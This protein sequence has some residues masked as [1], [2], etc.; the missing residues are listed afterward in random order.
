MPFDV[1]YVVLFSA[2]G[3][4]TSDVQQ[5]YRNIFVCATM[6]RR[7]KVTEEDSD[8]DGGDRPVLA[9]EVKTFAPSG[10]SAYDKLKRK[11]AAEECYTIADKYQRPAH[12]GVSA[13]PIGSDLNSCIGTISVDRFLET[14]AGTGLPAPLTLT[15]SDGAKHIVPPFTSSLPSGAVAGGPL[16]DE[17]VPFDAYINAGGPVWAVAMCPYSS[18]PAQDSNCRIGQVDRYIAIGTSRVGFA[19]S[20]SMGCDESYVLGDAQRHDNLLQVWRVHGS[21]NIPAKVV[22][23]GRLQLS[24]TKKSDDPNYVPKPKGRPRKYPRPEGE[25]AVAKIPRPKGRPRKYPRSEGEEPASKKPAG[26]AEQVALGQA[27]QE[28]EGEDSDAMMDVEAVE[29]EAPAVSDSEV[30]EVRSEL[31]YCV[32]L[33]GRGPTWAVKW[34]PFRLSD[35]ASSIGVVAVVNGDGSCVILQLPC[36]GDVGNGTVFAEEQLTLC[37]VSSPGDMVTSVAW[38]PAVV[39]R[40]ACGLTDGS[41][42]L[43]RVPAKTLGNHTSPTLTVPEMHLVDTQQL[44]SQIPS[45]AA[46]RAVQFCPY[47]P[48]LLLVAGQ[49][50][51][52]VR[53]ATLNCETGECDG[54]RLSLIAGLEP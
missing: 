45:L 54:S 10:D 46:V 31:S 35:S 17:T 12:D 1:Q 47:D 27:E 24:K 14:S 38:C 41:V 53:V 26:A 4:N 8:V 2:P 20:S 33:K 25:E 39:G 34:C 11:W 44:E 5:C 16:L 52:K 28:E 3:T 22:A 7:K 40:F 13:T 42:T 29:Q 50:E 36:A 32:A 18:A 21:Y 9:A 43:W 48:S 30:C 6:G 51:V 49:D 19:G 37:V 15:Y 23:G